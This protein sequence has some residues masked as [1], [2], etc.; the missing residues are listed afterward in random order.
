MRTPV[1]QAKMVLLEHL[2]SHHPE[3]RRPEFRRP[4]LNAYSKL[5]NEHARLDTGKDEKHPKI[6]YSWYAK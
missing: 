2:R 1:E 6:E 4:W 3:F 5:V